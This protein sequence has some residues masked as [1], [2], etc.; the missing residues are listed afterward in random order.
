MGAV[1]S[2]A[3]AFLIARVGGACLRIIWGL[4]QGGKRKTLDTLVELA[5]DLVLKAEQTGLDGDTKYDLVW[6][7]LLTETASR[8]VQVAAWEANLAIEL[9]V[10]ELNAGLLG[11]G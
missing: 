2:A 8:A 7:W 5:R 4:V 3:L 10:G 9:A 11:K 1:F 6:G